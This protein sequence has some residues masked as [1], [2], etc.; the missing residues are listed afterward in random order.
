MEWFRGNSKHRKTKNIRKI[1]NPGHHMRFLVGH[2]RT[3]G[4]GLTLTIAKTMIFYS[5]DYDL[6]IRE[7]ERLEIIV[8][9]P[10]VR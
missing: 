6:E 7:Q 2:P 1:M 9:E 3:G 8:L 4:Y 10:K 5:N